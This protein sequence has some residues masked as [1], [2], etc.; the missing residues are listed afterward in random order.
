MSKMDEYYADPQRTGPRPADRAANWALGSAIAS[1]VL[2][3]A[4]TWLAVNLGLGLLP[5]L[6]GLVGWVIA[7]TISIGCALG[8][9]KNAYSSLTPGILRKKAWGAIGVSIFSIVLV[10]A[11]LFAL[12][13]AA[14]RLVEAG[15]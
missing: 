6:L 15:G 14:Q 12:V 10:V 5:L 9:L 2:V 7:W 3:G 13:I 8:A 11:Y 4:G 1:I